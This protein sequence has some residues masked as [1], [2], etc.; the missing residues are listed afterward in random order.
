MSRAN[1]FCV[2]TIRRREP[3]SFPK[4]RVP[5]AVAS[6]SRNN[7]KTRICVGARP[8]QL[9]AT[10][11]TLPL[12]ALLLSRTVRGTLHGVE[13]AVCCRQEFFNGVTVLGEYGGTNAHRDWRT[14]SIVGDAFADSRCHLL[15]SLRARLREDYGKF[16]ASIA[17]SSVNFAAMNLENVC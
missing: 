1:G 5:S 12:R 11:F 9:Q 7:L 6:F 3:E 17:G 10:L 13:R 8:A 14:F 4:K 2:S 15:G 16:V